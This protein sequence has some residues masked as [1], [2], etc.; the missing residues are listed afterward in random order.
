MELPLGARRSVGSR[1]VQGPLSGR[2]VLHGTSRL[3]P[4]PRAL[5]TL[6]VGS[7]LGQMW[8]ESP[9]DGQGLPDGWLC[10]RQS[11]PPPEMEGGQALGGVWQSWR[12]LGARL[13]PHPCSEGLLQTGRD[14]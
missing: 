5:K 11:Q 14:V 12:A 6:A 8:L 13:H 9:G 1:G 4:A 3:L 2:R 7:Q 10:R